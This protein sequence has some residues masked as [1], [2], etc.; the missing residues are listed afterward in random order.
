M[1]LFNVTKAAGEQSGEVEVAGKRKYRLTRSLENI[2][3]PLADSLS[4][5]EEGL[6]KPSVGAEG[7]LSGLEHPNRSY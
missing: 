3:S 2:D 7:T 5:V 6:P 1:I 4:D